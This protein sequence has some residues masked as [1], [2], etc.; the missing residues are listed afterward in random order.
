MKL[1]L[2]KIRLDGGTQTRARIH[3]GI[4][5]DYAEDMKSGAPFPP[6]IVFHND[7]NH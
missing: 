6:L 3:E 5:E 2:K 4:I 7:K 1:P